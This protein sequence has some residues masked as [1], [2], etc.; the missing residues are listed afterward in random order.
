ME[1]GPVAGHPAGAD[2]GGT[3]ITP[4]HGQDPAGHRGI[5][6]GSDALR[7]GALQQAP[8]QFA[9]PEDGA[10]LGNLHRVPPG[11]GELPQRHLQETGHILQVAAGAGGAAVVGEKV[12]DPALLDV[13]HLGVLA[14]HL[15]Q[16][17]MVQAGLPAGAQKMGPDFGDGRKI[18]L[19][20]ILAV[21]GDHQGGRFRKPQTL[22]IDRQAAIIPPEIVAV[23]NDGV[24]PAPPQDPV[25]IGIHQLHIPAA[26]V[27]AAGE[28]GGRTP[29]F[30]LMAA[31]HRQRPPGAGGCGR[32]GGRGGP[33]RWSAP[34]G[35]GV[36]G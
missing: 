2:Q 26:E 8:H 12:E 16:D 35:S 22:P 18:L 11:R 34:A 25:G 14:A 24:Q 20:E 6:P 5:D 17:E 31:G 30:Q 15:Q 7:L 19:Q 9:F 29:G 33:L 28:V 21:A 27:E 10:G 3:A 1:H 36:P 4:H 13:N 23:K 32:R